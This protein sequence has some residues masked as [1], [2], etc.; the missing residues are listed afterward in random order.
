MAGG[1][2][3]LQSDRNFEI[4][5]ILYWDN[6]DK[7]EQDAVEISELLIEINLHFS[8]ESGFATGTIA[9]ADAGNFMETHFKGTGVISM[10]IYHFGHYIGESDTTRLMKYYITGISSRRQVKEYGNVI[11]FDL[12]TDGFFRN[13]LMRICKRY[14]G[15]VGDHIRSVLE[16]SWDKK[17]PKG[18]QLGSTRGS[19][20]TLTKTKLVTVNNPENEYNFISCN[21]KPLKVIN[22]LADRA[23]FTN[24]GDK[25]V[26]GFFV[27]RRDDYLFDSFSKR[28]GEDKNV[29]F[30]FQRSVA[31]RS[32]A[33]V[34]TSDKF[35]Y[36]T[37]LD[38]QFISDMD[39]VR[40][41]DDGLLSSK[42]HRYNI[43]RKKWHQDE[44][45]YSD[46]FISQYGSKMFKGWDGIDPLQNPITDYN[47]SR[48][49]STGYTE[50]FDDPKTE[51]KPFDYISRRAM[52]LGSI[53]QIK[54]SFAIPG[55]SHAEVGEPVGVII[56]TQGVT[57]KNASLEETKTYV[58]A[59][60]SGKYFV[61]AINYRFNRNNA[62]TTFECVKPELN[63][64]IEQFLSMI[65]AENK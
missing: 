14:T 61:T 37:M 63:E 35:A 19:D 46:N 23:V 21:W 33:F 62:V 12:V 40:A 18:L 56:P 1:N 29:K 57:Q 49:F 13:Q 60:Y 31:D 22:F 52:F 34:P 16:E 55:F 4:K 30:I 41:F 58:D 3:K 65:G 20:Y 8:L 50:V 38:F 17:H 11:V 42:T 54:I 25:M 47:L 45:Q 27:E 39:L 64:S 24:K 44:I 26:D 28:H 43:M 5:K 48:I 9:L 2:T 53:N 7:P 15:N 32:T 51:R 36:Y 6:V 59:T 10:D